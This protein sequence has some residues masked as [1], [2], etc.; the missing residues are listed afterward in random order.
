MRLQARWLFLVASAG[1][2]PPLVAQ[3]A[4][5]I[6][7]AFFVAGPSFTGIVDEYGETQWAAPKPRARDGWVLSNGNI[8]IVWSKE[9]LEFD[10]KKKVCWRYRLEA[11]N[12]EL[13]TAQ[14]LPNGNTLI[15]E[16]GPKP[17]LREIAASGETAV[18]FA[19]QPETDNAHMQTR[20]ARKLPNGDYL[21]PHLLA[22]CVKQYTAD[23]KVVATIR[24]DLDELGGRKAE[25]WPFTAIRLPAGG[26]LVG[27]THGNKVCEFDAAG[28]VVWQVHNEDVGG[29]LDDACGVQRLPNGNTVIASYHARPGIKL[30]EVDRSKKVVWRYSGKHR[31]HHFQV[32]TTN[33]E[34]LPG[35]PLR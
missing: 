18:E 35:V 23:G 15:T 19:L 24:T 4:R 11:P 14:R 10:S 21:V 27:C 20:M 28:D 5:P 29:I 6:R 26:T 31:V 7:H 17:R 9:V 16:L 34:P 13:G 2:L 22:H 25:N 1:V 3:D 8:L 30:L 32:L 12:K 33:G